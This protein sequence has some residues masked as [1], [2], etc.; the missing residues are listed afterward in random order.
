MTKNSDQS[1]QVETRNNGEDTYHETNDPT[2]QINENVEDGTQQNECPETQKETLIVDISWN[3]SD[4]LN[5]RKVEENFFSETNS[6][7]TLEYYTLKESEDARHTD[8]KFPEQAF[9]DLNV[10]KFSE[11]DELFLRENDSE[12]SEYS[13]DEPTLQSSNTTS[14]KRIPI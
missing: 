1:K 10:E 11:N 13:L 3:E 8:E 12:S 9:S 5:K 7:P 14:R 4:A 2:L 6:N